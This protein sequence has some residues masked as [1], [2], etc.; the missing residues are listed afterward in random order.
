MVMELPFH[1]EATVAV[2]AEELAAVA[3]LARGSFGFQGRYELRPF[4]P[5]LV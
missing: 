4:L 2:E 5:V 1:S 3:G